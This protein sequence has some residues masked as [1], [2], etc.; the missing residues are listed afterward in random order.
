MGL[1]LGGDPWGDEL[2]A[3]LLLDDAAFTEEDEAA[4]CSMLWDDSNELDLAL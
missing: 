4:L 2:P 1:W 3:E